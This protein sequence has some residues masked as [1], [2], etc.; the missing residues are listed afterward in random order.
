M[1]PSRNALAT[2]GAACSARVPEDYLI[3][4]NVI[5]FRGEIE[6]NLLAYLTEGEL[7]GVSLIS[8]G[9][10]VHMP[11]SGLFVD[12]DELPVP[13]WTHPALARNL[14]RI[15]NPKFTK[16]PHAVMMASRGCSYQCV[17]CVPMSI[18]FARELEYQRYFGKK[19]PPSIAG[20]GR[21]V[22]E[23]ERLKA[24]GFESVMIVDD[25]FLWGKERTLEICEGVGHLGI[26]WGC[27]SRADFLTDEEIVGSLGRAGCTSI[28]IGVESFDQEVLDHIRKDLKLDAVYRALELLKSHGI[29]PKVNLMSGTCSKETPEDI[30]ETIDTLDRLKVRNVMFSIATPFKG[31]EFYDRCREEGYLV[32]DSDNIDPFNKSVVSYPSLP[33]ETLERLQRQAYRR[34]YL[35][36][37]A[38]L[39]RLGEIAYLDFSL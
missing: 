30:E 21:V 28:D 10:A 12:L 17:F 37:G 24:D 2:A 11:P 32:D 1:R 15:F 27:L 14:G 20:A 39:R 31:T 13:C 6:E 23:F 19:P 34:F 38:V 36:P 9:R 5:V 26:E 35:R 16:R 8:G 25:Q 18:S 7:V 29:E 4:P 33:K 22:A 3:H